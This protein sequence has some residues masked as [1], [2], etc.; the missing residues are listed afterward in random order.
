MISCFRSYSCH[1][2]SHITSSAQ[3]LGAHLMT[4][5]EHKQ[6]FSPELQ[7][8]QDSKEDSAMKEMEI[9]PDPTPAPKKDLTQPEN[10]ESSPT[11]TQ[12]GVKSQGG[13]TLVRY[14]EPGEQGDENVKPRLTY[15]QLIAR[16]LRDCGGYATLSQIYKVRFGRTVKLTENIFIN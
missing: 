9:L 2:C 14:G 16:A 5:P 11:D 4:H 12:Y 13:A 10:K 7:K 8:D 3:D 1:L 6:Q 15:S